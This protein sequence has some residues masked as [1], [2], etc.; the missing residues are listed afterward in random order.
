MIDSQTT[1]DIIPRPNSP[2]SM[3]SILAEKANTHKIRIQKETDNF[4]NY[5]TSSNLSAENS[6]KSSPV[7]SIIESSRKEP[8]QGSTQN[9]KY[10]EIPEQL[11]QYVTEEVWESY[12]PAR[13]ES[14]VKMFQ[15]PNS[16]FYRN[17]PPGD[18]QIFGAFTSQEE[19]LFIQRINY[20]RNDLKIYDRLWG[21]FAVPFKGRLGYQC[22]NF[23]RHLIDIGVLKKC[24]PKADG[25]RRSRGTVAPEV[26]KQLE[27]EAFAFIK[28]CLLRDKPITE[29]QLRYDR[30]S[31]STNSNKSSEISASSR[32]GTAADSEIEHANDGNE[33]TNDFPISPS[34]TDTSE[35][36][37]T[38]TASKTVP[39]NSIK[40][41]SKA[42]QEILQLLPT[43]V[44]THSKK[45]ASNKILVENTNCIYQSNI[46]VEG[47]KNKQ[48]ESKN[49]EPFS[50]PDNPISVKKPKSSPISQT[51]KISPISKAS[52]ISKTS[53]N[54]QNSQSIK[55]SNKRLLKIIQKNSKKSKTS[56]RV[57]KTITDI[58]FAPDPITD[59]PMENPYLDPYAGVVMEK[60]TWRD[61]FNR[62][63][64][65]SYDIYV[66]KFKD[67]LPVTPEVFEE[68]RNQIVNMY[69]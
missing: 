8:Q 69:I 5:Q 11:R 19:E 66:K 17:R 15:N 58:H 31:A 36:L 60:S 16:F 13:R 33:E 40:K 10:D 59:K 61:F 26:I 22:M 49:P 1:F 52:Q 20:F 43:D 27:Q 53:Q 38:K 32:S 65:S 57:R 12:Y 35:N 39:K 48:I 41:P 67:L 3:L 14:F 45:L 24:K 51:S 18:P 4:D 30:K 2:T 7:S 56:K 6:N 68:Y 42:L 37:V 46:Y 44:Q 23:Y 54:K 64:T 50:P 47:D 34:S 21:L 28:E 62:K 55:D 29:P 63:V 9:L 25:M